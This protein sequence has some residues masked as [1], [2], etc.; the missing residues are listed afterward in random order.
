M[1]GELHQR[2]IKLNRVALP[3]QDDAAKI[4]CGAL[5]YV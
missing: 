3:P 1:P 4:L 5:R 2:R